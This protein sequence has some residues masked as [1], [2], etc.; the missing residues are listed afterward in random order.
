MGE[1]SAIEWTDHTFNPWIGC[2]KVAPGCAHC[3]A[4]SYAKRYG[5]AT[6][7]PGGTRVKTSDANW[8][9]PI[10]WNREAEAAGVRKRV[11][12]ASLADVFEKWEGAVVH[13]DG[14]RLWIAEC[15]PDRFVRQ[16][17]RDENNPELMPIERENISNGIF[18][19][20]TLDDVRL[21]LFRLIDQTPWLDWLLLTKRPEN[22]ERMWPKNDCVELDDEGRGFFVHHHECMGLCEHSCTGDLPYPGA[23]MGWRQYPATV[24]GGYR[25]NVWLGTSISDQ[26]TADGGLPELLKCFVH[27]PLLFISAEPLLGRVDLR[28]WLHG[29]SC[30]MNPRAVAIHTVGS[31]DG[32]RTCTCGAV[33][34]RVGW[35]IVG[36]E[37]G[38]GA[39]CCDV[40]D[41]WDAAQQC[42]EAG[43]PCFVKQLGARP[44]LNRNHPE[45]NQVL[46]AGHTQLE[47]ETFAKDL[48]EYLDHIYAVSLRDKKGG[49]WN[50]WPEQLRI[51]EFPEP[52]HA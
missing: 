5:K 50:E 26:E 29:P 48:G 20:A 27:V 44:I 23:R 19:P 49:D 43:V 31:L 51:R 10:K 21:A 52:I 6:W 14:K 45:C 33:T 11:F 18:R 22:V 3:Y 40:G 28:P 35:A 24:P 34:T 9:N 17:F 30:Q 46:P 42:R 47:L 1:N 37:S 25:P 13:S 8:R 4:E 38:S 32:L 2:T 41:L 15:E 16:T 7:G 39:R 36:G 12:C